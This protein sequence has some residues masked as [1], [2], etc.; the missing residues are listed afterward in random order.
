MK[1]RNLG[2]Q[3]KQS[4]APVLLFI[5]L[6]FSTVELL[7]AVD[8]QNGIVNP[9]R[10]YVGSSYCNGSASP[11]CFD[12]S[13]FVYYL[14]SPYIEGLPRI[15]RQLAHIGRPVRQADLRPG[16]LVFFATSP[17]AGIIS[18]V[19]LYIGQNSIIHAIS[20]GPNRGVNITP[21]D[22]RYWRTRYHSAAR[23]LSETTPAAVSTDAAKFARGT[24]SGP[25]VHGEPQGR[26]TLVLNNG[27]VYEGEFRQGE[28]HGSGTYI[29]KSGARFDG[30]FKDG[31]FHGKGVYVKA[32]GTQLSGVWENGSL[33]ER[34]ADP[35]STAR[36]ASSP[37]A[38]EQPA[39]APALYTEKAVSPWDSW[40][41][42]VMGD[43]AAWKAEEEQSFE[44]WKKQNNPD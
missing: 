42:Y 40:E 12:C 13:G 36:R 22:S 6:L 24:Y 38:S 37:S 25:L 10:R 35:D 9:A 11:P 4:L 15:S 19:A 7:P 2:K 29:W 41:G 8:I 18:H 16:D 27:D 32:D 23:L 31:V 5:I 26:G 1:P 14:F 44:E 21:L 17:A 34:S 33:A 43:Y 39:S 20:D 3:L 30:E 28:F